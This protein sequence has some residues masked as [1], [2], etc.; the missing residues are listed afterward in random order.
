MTFKYI[1]IPKKFICP[2]T[3]DHIMV[4]PV[5]TDDGYTYERNAISKWLE[6]NDT[7]PT[8]KVLLTDKKLRP[9]RLLKS[10]ISQFVEENRSQFERELIIAAQTGDMATVNLV[11]DLG[12]NINAQNEQG[13]TALYFAIKTKHIEITK[14]LLARNANTEL[15]INLGL[16]EANSP[17]LLA[18]TE[19]GHMHA[20]LQSI[21]AT[22]Q[23]IQA[24]CDKHI[25]KRD[26][27]KLE[28]DEQQ[29]YN[30]QLLLIL[31]KLEAMLEICNRN[32]INN[33]TDFFKVP[34][35]DGEL[36]IQLI[37][38]CKLLL[39]KTPA[40]VKNKSSVYTSNNMFSKSWRG[41]ELSHYF[42]HYP[43]GDID[44]LKLEQQQISKIIANLELQ[45]IELNCPVDELRELLTAWKHAIETIKSNLA[46]INTYKTQA[47]AD[48]KRQKVNLLEAQLLKKQY[49]HDMLL[50]LEEVAIK[51]PITKHCNLTSHEQ[52]EFIQSQI[53]ILNN[54]A[55]VEATQ[56]LSKLTAIDLVESS[57]CNF[58]HYVSYLGQTE[59]A[60]M[61]FH[62][63]PACLTQID[64][65]GNSA[66]HYAAMQA[67]PAML[68]KLVALGADLNVI[69]KN[70]D[71]PLHYAA[72][73]GSQEVIDYLLNQGQ[74]DQHQNKQGLTPYEIA[75]HFDHEALADYMVIK[76]LASTNATKGQS[77]SEVLQTQVKNQQLQINQQQQQIVQLQ[78]R[79]SELEQFIQAWQKTSAT[80][81]SPVMASSQSVVNQYHLFN[82]NANRLVSSQPHS[83]LDRILDIY[84]QKA[85]EACLHTHYDN[86]LSHI[87]QAITFIG[88]TISNAQDD[89]HRYK[90]KYYLAVAYY[91]QGAICEQAHR[92]MEA[93]SSLQKALLLQEERSDIQ[94][95]LTYNIKIML[96]KCRSNLQV[97]SLSSRH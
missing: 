82:H 7:D 50:A 5:T 10:E 68:I 38:Q 56:P 18:Q 51:Y 71:T 54:I 69:N 46:D 40:K 96:E 33:Q 93:T 55:L 66:V 81:N 53:K 48:Y 58:F 17:L 45:L 79:V 35:Q 9:N 63:N 32:N 34:P 20:R 57:Q 62:K 4:D 80:E 94:S 41:I 3:L 31:Q 39:E 89:L 84:Y 88:N 30:S 61:L 13:W 65:K 8:S 1:H 85:D 73:A 91:K 70:N 11:L 12:I 52:T 15:E 74:D 28:I 47:V 19:N 97:A 29:N 90:L 22:V 6:T 76:R 64:A 42:R 49:V 75:I 2:I 92:F 14:L 59:L 26:A 23:A 37:E 16:P 87:S 43:I 25:N 83:E 72:M 21:S 44:K 27:K 67:D 36:A 60:E 78:Q 95:D 86:A 77:L 24:E